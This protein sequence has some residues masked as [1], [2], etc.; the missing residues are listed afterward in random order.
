MHDRESELRRIPLP[1]TWVNKLPYHYADPFIDDSSLP[2]NM[3]V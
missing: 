3:R 1:R 2:I